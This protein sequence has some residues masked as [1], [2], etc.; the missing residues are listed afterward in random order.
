M[1]D[2]VDQALRLAGERFDE[3]V[4]SLIRAAHGDRS[5]LAM[6]AATVSTDGPTHGDSREQIAFALL[7]EAAHR[8][9]AQPE[10]RSVG[11]SR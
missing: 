3:H 4:R 8:S 7:L 2:L 5:R 6:A 10:L 1:E 9:A 11:S